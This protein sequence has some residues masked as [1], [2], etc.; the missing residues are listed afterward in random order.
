MRSAVVEWRA[1]HRVH[2]GAVTKFNGEYFNA[3]RTIV[4]FLVA[5]LDDLI[6]RGLLALERP[7]SR[8]CQR[9]CVTHQGQ[10]RYAE[11]HSF[12]VRMGMLTDEHPES[13]T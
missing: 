10:A 2:E 1:L 5:A 12:A 9:V 7:D 3:G 4:D 6:N 13:T 11:L 8:G